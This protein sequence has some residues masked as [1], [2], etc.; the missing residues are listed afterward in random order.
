MSEERFESLETKIAFQEDLIQKLDDALSD[1]QQQILD[2]RVQLQH[3]SSQ[4]KEMESFA[5]D[6][7]EPEPPPPHY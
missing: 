4:V 5:P 2:L 1:Q 7:S 6:S 3:V